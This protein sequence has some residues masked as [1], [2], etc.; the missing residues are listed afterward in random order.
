MAPI[1]LA[2]MV[3]PVARAQVCWDYRRP[4]RRLA[5]KINRARAKRG[6]DRLRLDPQISKVSRVH[7][8]EM[9]KRRKVFH[10]ADSTL[11]GRVTNWRVLGENVGSTRAGARRIFRSMMRSA[12]HR[13]NMLDGTFNYIGVGTKRRRGRLWVTITLQAVDNPGTTLRMP[14][15]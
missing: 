14:R 15:C 4:E 5:R 8:R 1:V 12:L 7:T 13:A 9:I 6:I 10:T 3:V 2:A 11:A